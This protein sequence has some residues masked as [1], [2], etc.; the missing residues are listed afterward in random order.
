MF[1]GTFDPPHI[2]HL[3]AGLYAF[4]AISLDRLLFVISNIPWQKVGHRRITPAAQRLA[5]VEAAIAGHDGFEASTV[6]IERGGESY[7]ADTL[8]ALQER[9]PAA[10]LF[11]VLGADAAAGIPTWRRAERLADLATVVIVDRPGTTDVSLPGFRV[12]EVTMPLL[13]ISSSDLRH[14]LGRD[15]P[16]DWL[17]P[18][19][20]RSLV[21]GLR[22]YRERP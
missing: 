2:G 9:H 10:E 17:V 1:G 20:V 3:V 6:E 8:V 22:L 15:L 14:R 18:D 11:L 4:H 7:T 5:M 12:E 21:Q 16:V 13:D 19:A